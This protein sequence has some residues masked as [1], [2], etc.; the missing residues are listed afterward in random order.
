M[1]RARGVVG[2]HVNALSDCDA[3]REWMGNRPGG[4][5]QE[6]AGRKGTSPAD[7]LTSLSIAGVPLPSFVTKAVPVSFLMA[8]SS[9]PW[10]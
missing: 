3:R 4:R 1:D 7:K 6:E 10:L 5:W 9:L 8:F 2:R